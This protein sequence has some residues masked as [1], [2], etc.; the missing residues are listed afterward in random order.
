M[1]IDCAGRAKWGSM[2]GAS[3]GI[4]HPRA[5]V[6]GE[7][8]REREREKEKERKKERER[9]RSTHPHIRSRRTTRS[10]L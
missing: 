5:A 9:E 6:V 1:Y 8:E 7:P 3:D 10:R 2:T 4:V